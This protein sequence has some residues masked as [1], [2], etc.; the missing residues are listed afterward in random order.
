ML[1]HWFTGSYGAINYL[2]DVVILI[3][4]FYSGYKFFDRRQEK[5]QQ[6]REKKATED[7]LATVTTVVEASVR[8]LM[9]H[10]NSIVEKS[11]KEELSD[12]N[13][14]ITHQAEVLHRVEHEVTFNDGTS[15]KD[16]QKRT[17]SLLNK[18]AISLDSVHDV[19]IRREQDQKAVSET[20]NRI[21]IRQE[22]DSTSID[23]LS[24]GLA[25][26]LG[27]HEGL[28]GDK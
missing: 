11:V 23:K 1:I 22:K 21:E 3:G 20:I 5:K 7:L 15:M 2:T 13:D 28:P 12:V 26:H 19:Q 14:R 9:T 24:T 10:V 8:E 4:A 25:A 17:E 18:V 6:K 16:S 27:A